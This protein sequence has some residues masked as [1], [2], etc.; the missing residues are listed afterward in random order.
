MPLKTLEDEILEQGSP[1]TPLAI[2]GPDNGTEP[3][4]P[5]PDNGENVRV[6]IRIRPFN[7]RER[8]ANSRSCVKL[9]SHTSLSLQTAPTPTQFTFDNI[10]SET[11]SQDRMFRVA[12]KTYDGDLPK[13]TMFLTRTDS[14]GLILVL[15]GVV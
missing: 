14:L 6:I 5:L 3:S 13:I 12:G 7:E 15:C 8:N 10:V 11:S 1:R 9:E 4:S 2:L